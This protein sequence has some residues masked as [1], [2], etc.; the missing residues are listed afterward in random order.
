[1]KPHNVNLL[2]ALI[3]ITLGLWGYLASSSP[4]PTALIPVGF[5]IVLALA[6]P[7]LSRDNKV[8]AHVVVL[9]TLALTFALIMPLRGVLARED[10]SAAVRVGV[11]LAG[12]LAAMVV[13]IKSFVD[14]RRSR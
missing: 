12:C 7:S 8:V 5:G 6:T 4:S 1:M 2:N 11:M 9:L 10:V 3:L 13:Y 14:A